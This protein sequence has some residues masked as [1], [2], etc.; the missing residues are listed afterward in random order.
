V[1]PPDGRLRVTFLDVGQG[2]A[3]FVE[4][5]DGRRLLVD[6]GPGG[7]RRFDVGERVV[8]PFLWNRAVVSLDAVVMTH[9]DPD[10]AGGLAAILR[11]FRVRELWENGIADPLAEELGRLAARQGTVRRRLTA[12][13]RIWLGVVPFTVLNPPAPPLT[14][15]PRG[16][17]SDEN[18]N[19]LVLRVD[20]GL[21]SFL[22]TGD[23]EREGEAE[24]VARRRPL[25]HRIL[26]VGHHGSRYSTTEE[27]LGAGRP[28]L[29]VISAGRR[30]PFNHPTP[31]VLARLG[32]AGVR[33]YRTDR[34]GA[35]L[36]DTDGTSL[37]V[38]RWASRATDALRLASTP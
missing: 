12:G 21:A 2:D 26:K 23:L 1:R 35:V 20:W 9:A 22:L 7:E 14:G 19:S 31:E 10:H 11:R 17:A 38:T 27:F 5:P 28:A 8:A 30:N 15:S 25:D 13:D 32:Q 34:D 24:L 29:A 4:L 37:T 16:P 6:G 36:I 33:I 3:A 18:N